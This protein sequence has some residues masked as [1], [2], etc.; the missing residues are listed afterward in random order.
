MDHTHPLYHLTPP[1]HKTI[2]DG[3]LFCIFILSLG[4]LALCHTACFSLQTA[5]TAIKRTK[6]KSFTFYF[7]ILF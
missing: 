5:T 4:K 2:R 3:A 1:P 7:I 6:K